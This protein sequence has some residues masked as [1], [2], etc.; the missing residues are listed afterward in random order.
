MKVFP[1]V[2]RFEELFVLA[3]NEPIRF[4]KAEILKRL[5]A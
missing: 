2:V 4:N 3:S 1:Y 5:E